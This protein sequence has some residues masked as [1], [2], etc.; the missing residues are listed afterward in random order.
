MK[1]PLNTSLVA[2]G[3]LAYR[4][5]ITKWPPGGPKMAD[6]VWKGSIPKWSDF[7]DFGLKLNLFGQKGPKMVWF[8]TQKSGQNEEK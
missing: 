7:S 5:Q 4:L 1:N 8:Y 2:K 3:A 6:G